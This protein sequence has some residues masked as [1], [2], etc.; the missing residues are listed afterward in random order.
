[1]AT[2]NYKKHKKRLLKE[3]RERYQNL[4]EEDKI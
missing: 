3:A 2:N 4:C 1:M